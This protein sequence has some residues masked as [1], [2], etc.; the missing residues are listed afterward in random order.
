VRTVAFILASWRPDAP[1]GMERAVA[2]SAAGLVATGHRALI[3]T[4]DRTAPGR[5]AG[6]AV[7]VLDTLRVPSPCG[8]HTLRA[9]IDAAGDRLPAELLSVFAA[10]HADAAVYVD[11]LWGLGRVMPTNSPPRRILAVHVLGHDIDLAA[12]L[13]RAE[14]VIAPSAVVP[15]H[16]ATRGYDTT[17]WRVIPNAL[18]AEAHPPPPARRR[19]LREHGPIRVLARLGPEKGIPELLA[20]AVGSPH[21]RRVEVALSAAGFEASPGSQQ[22]LLQTCRRLADPS[23]AAILPGLPWHRVAGWLANSA[24][25]IVPSKAETFG[26]VALEAMAGGT[27]VVAFD[28]DNLPPL[29]GAGG[30]TVPLAR[31]HAGLWRA[32][33]ELLAEPVRYE[34]T[35][36]AGYYQTRD[37]RPAH[38]ADLLVKVVS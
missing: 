6:A 33:R 36:R 10:H 26:L 3:L 28:I 15:R 31:G 38:I 8:D 11:G 1:A 9:A 13:E 18:L 12:A 17:R 2:A 16:A 35:S 24:A 22:R 7:H 34:Q 32:T 37:Y 30:T 21:R 4:A 14:V 23:G 29:I 25:V 20:T 5:Y 19:W 27:P